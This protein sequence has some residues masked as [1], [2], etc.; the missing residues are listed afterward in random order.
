MKALACEEE[1]IVELAVL[2]ACAHMH[3][4]A[5]PYMCMYACECVC[6][7]NKSSSERLNYKECHIKPRGLAASQ[8][9]VVDDLAFV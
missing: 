5:C 4:C 2:Y 1:R 8:G 6:F 9:L 7:C 3:V